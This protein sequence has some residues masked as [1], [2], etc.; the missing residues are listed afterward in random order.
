MNV[1]RGVDHSHLAMLAVEFGGEIGLDH[2]GLL[3]G[4]LGTS[5]L[6]S[7]GAIGNLE[8]H[9]AQVLCATPA[10]WACTQ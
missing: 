10:Q 1:Q 8:A 2:C 3:G 6:S 7:R 5:T 9:H 4:R